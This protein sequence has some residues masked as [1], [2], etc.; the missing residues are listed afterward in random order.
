M[1]ELALFGSFAVTA[2]L[3]VGSMFLFWM[4]TQKPWR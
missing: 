2:A 1:V 4:Y 3:G